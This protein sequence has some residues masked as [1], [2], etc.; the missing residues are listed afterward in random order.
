[1]AEFEYFSDGYVP[2]LDIPSYFLSS[3]MWNELRSNPK[4]YPSVYFSLNPVTENL[5]PASVK[6]MPISLF[7]FLAI[8]NDGSDVS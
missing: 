6:S 5:M 4:E 3:N 7:M 2:A 1:M 8:F